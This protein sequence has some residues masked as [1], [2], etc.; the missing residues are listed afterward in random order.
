MEHLLTPF[1]PRTWCQCTQI[2]LLCFKLRT[3]SS[4]PVGSQWADGSQA[5]CWPIRAPEPRTQTGYITTL[6]QQHPLLQ[7]Q[8]QLN[9]QL[10]EKPN[11]PNIDWTFIWACKCRRSV[12]N[13]PFCQKREVTHS[14]YLRH[15]IM[16]CQPL[17]NT[18]T[19]SHYTL[20]VLYLSIV[21]T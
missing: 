12:V 7:D 4:G 2:C 18:R 10:S 6:L 21:W 16:S 19:C 8:C 14:R 9:V 17:W 3:R 15:F 5:A 13:P 1:F 11:A 20:C